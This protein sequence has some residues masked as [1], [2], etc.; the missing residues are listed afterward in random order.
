MKPP[1]SVLQINPVTGGQLVV[2]NIRNIPV[3]PFSG[4]QTNIPATSTVNLL[5]HLVLG[6]II[7]GYQVF[8]DQQRPTSYTQ[9]YLQYHGYQRNRDKDIL[10]PLLEEEQGFPLEIL[11]KNMEQII[12][13]LL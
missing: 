11:R 13:F 8:F 9:Q 4:V 2:P 6:V 3:I 10:T 7:P 1:Q 12:F 5:V